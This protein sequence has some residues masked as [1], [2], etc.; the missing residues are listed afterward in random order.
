LLFPSSHVIYIFALPCLAS[1][2]LSQRNLDLILVQSK[3]QEFDKFA[4]EAFFSSNSSLF[5]IGINYGKRKDSFHF[6]DSQQR[7]NSRTYS[8]GDGLPPSLAA[9][10]LSFDQSNSVAVHST[11]TN[12]SQM[13]QNTH[14]N[15]QLKKDILEINNS[16]DM[17]KLI[18]STKKKLTMIDQIEER[19]R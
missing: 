6:Y 18:R 8:L 16:A 15:F 7:H 14:S 3:P 17:M 2:R 10:K 4:E 11:S 13:A 19:M 5:G 1:V 9:R 12:P